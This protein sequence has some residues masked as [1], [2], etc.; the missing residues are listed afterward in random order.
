M[1]DHR[2]DSGSTPS[3]KGTAFASANRFVSL[4]FF[5]TR[6][7]LR[8]N[9]ID[10]SAVVKA[11][12]PVGDSPDVFATYLR[13]RFDVSVDHT[14]VYWIGHSGGVF[15]G[16]QSL[17]VNPRITRAVAY[18]GGATAV[19]VFANPQSS[20]HATLV[21]LLGSAGIAEGTSD[22]LKTLQIAKWILDPADPANFARYVVRASTTPLPNPFASGALS[23]LYPALATIGAAQPAREVLSQISLCDGTVPNAQNTLLAGLLGRTDD[24]SF[25]SGYAVPTPDTGTTAHVQWFSS[26][27]GATGG[28]SCPTGQVGH[29]NP[30]DLSNPSLAQQAQGFMGGFLASPANLVTPVLP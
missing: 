23:L 25:V 16:T 26:Q 29:S 22:Y 5:R 8:Q 28:A 19:D 27:A 18:A 11:L 15:A 7:A 4:N 17:A 3:P 2:F 20:F 14:K 21:A 1:L 13:S 6:D 30:W 10:V 12:A 24:G 9:T